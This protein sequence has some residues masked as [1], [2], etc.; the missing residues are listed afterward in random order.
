MQ[1]SVV[2]KLPLS[3]HKAPNVTC[4]A[5]PHSQKYL[6]IK[7]QFWAPS[8]HF[9]RN[10]DASKKAANSGS[11]RHQTKRV[12]HNGWT[13][14]K[15]LVKQVWY[16]IQR[17]AASDYFLLAA[18]FFAA[19]AF[20]ITHH[21]Y[22]DRLAGTPPPSSD[23]QLY[24]PLQ[25]FSGQS[26][27]V[28]IG[29]L[30]ATLVT[31]L[32]KGCIETSHEQLSW[33]AA[34]AKPAELALLDSLFSRS[35][36]PPRLW[37]HRRYLGPEILVLLRFLLPFATIITPA[38][39]NVEL[40]RVE[41]SSIMAV[42][43]IDFRGGAFAD[44]LAFDRDDDSSGTYDYG[45]PLSSVTKAIVQ[46][47]VVGDVI[48]ITAPSPN[49]TYLTEF[50]GPALQCT[51]IP[52]FSALWTNM[53]MTLSNASAGMTSY[54]YLSWPGNST[55][56]WSVSDSKEYW[57]FDPPTGLTGSPVSLTMIGN[58]MSQS[59]AY[60]ATNISIV[61]C[62]LWNATYAAKIS[63]ENGAQSVS[64]NITSYI[65]AIELDTEVAA[66]SMASATAG[67]YDYFLT[68]S[69]LAVM[70]AFQDYITGEIFY[71][72]LDDLGGSPTINNTNMLMTILPFTNE[73]KALNTTGIW[74]LGSSTL[75][76]ISMKD[77]L[78][79]MFHNATLSLAS[80]TP[81][82]LSPTK[83]NTNV[84]AWTY[85]NICTYS[86]N[87]LWGAYGISIG[88][89]LVIILTVLYVVYSEK[90]F[91]KTDF[92]TILRVAHNVQLSHAIQ[93]SE[94]SGKAPLP[95]RLE[96]SLVY[97]PPPGKLATENTNPFPADRKSLLH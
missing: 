36:W 57:Y 68:W 35:L 77:A 79:A 61:Q 81:L 69:Y 85:Q 96:D 63:Y 72:L 8:D 90:G 91:H 52:Q 65:Q 75:G 5:V 38:Q 2:A 43:T 88:Y 45:G 54:F 56:P 60:S 9:T 28:A 70:D 18:N 22:Y 32:L 21:L 3:R 82:L 74:G 62:Q 80:Q 78:E 7:L 93:T 64:S 46:S 20:A 33:K 39:L 58:A 97:I 86:A 76:N 12:L 26:V 50:S 48:D 29:T 19:V 40:A 71:K 16:W 27:N 34:R 42:P 1:V 10:G 30:F 53:S 41:N 17:L 89:T 13:L 14:S 83:P 92:S 51:E 67:A 44:Q 47:L 23:S 84:T 37:I 49:S 66:P 59:T 4:A 11:I 6:F 95:E 73:L 15:K 94:T 55:Y 31:T 87:I 25:Q 24:G